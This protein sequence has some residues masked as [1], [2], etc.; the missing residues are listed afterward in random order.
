MSE[1]IFS[2]IPARARRPLRR[3]GSAS[4]QSA[5]TIA[6]SHDAALLAILAAP[7]RLGETAQL[8][9]LRKEAELRAAFAALSVTDARALHVR[10]ANPRPGDTLAEKFAGLVVERKQRLLVFLGDARRREAIAAAA[11][12]GRR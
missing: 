8:G 2:A 5:H 10:L 7:L 4:I 11:A 12:N 1:S 3:L 9:F 6:S